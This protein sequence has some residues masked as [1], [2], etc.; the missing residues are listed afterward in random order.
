[1]LFGNALSLLVGLPVSRPPHWLCALP[2]PCQG[3][4]PPLW[5]CAEPLPPRCCLLSVHHHAVSVFVVFWSD[6]SRR[7]EGCTVTVRPVVVTRGGVAV[8]GKRGSSVAPS[9]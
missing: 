3:A 5:Q 8:A 9:C 6:L 4:Q 1:M 2:P 7:D